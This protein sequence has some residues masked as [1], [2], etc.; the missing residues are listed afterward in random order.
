MKILSGNVPYSLA[1][2]G[3]VYAKAGRKADALQILD[4]LIY[5][6]R[7]GNPVNYSIALI[8]YQLGEKDKAFEWFEKSY[9]NREIWLTAIAYDP[10]WDDVRS[11][12]RGIALLKK[13]GLRK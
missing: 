6:S 2:L 8:Y 12:S 11:D 1:P 5:L 7:Q 3:W 4:T 9:E 10:L 13:M